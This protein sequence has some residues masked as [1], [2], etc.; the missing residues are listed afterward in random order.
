MKE[1]ENETG[2]EKAI[3]VY[4]GKIAALAS[5]I[6]KHYETVRLWLAQGFVPQ[7]SCKKVRAVTG[8]PLWELNSDVYESPEQSKAA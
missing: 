6:G 1:I 4:D 5:D 2:I 8:I 3:G 7:A